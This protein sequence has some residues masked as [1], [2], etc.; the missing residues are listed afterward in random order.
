MTSRVS[1]DGIKVLIS[2]HVEEVL[3][4]EVTPFGNGAKVGC[5]KE[6]IG[7]KIYLVVC[8]E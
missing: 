2:E 1:S 5:P 8:E 6:H 3:Q 4:G 7:K